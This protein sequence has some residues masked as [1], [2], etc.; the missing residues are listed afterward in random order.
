M[1]YQKHTFILANG[2]EAVLYVTT[3]PDMIFSMVSDQKDAKNAEDVAK[4]IRDKGLDVWSE[5]E[6]RNKKK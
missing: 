5:G 2:N 6:F 3:S 4:A 1:I